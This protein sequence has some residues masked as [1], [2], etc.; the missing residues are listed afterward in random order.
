MRRQPLPGLARPCRR[1]GTSP[2]RSR[3]RPSARRSSCRSSAP[4]LGS[5]GASRPSSGL[6]EVVEERAHDVDRRRAGVDP[7][8]EVGEPR[9]PAAAS[10]A[11]ADDAGQ[12][13]REVRPARAADCRP[14]RHR[15]RRRAGAGSQ[16]AEQA[17][18]VV[19]ENVP[20]LITTRS[21]GPHDVVSSARIVDRTPANVAVAE[22]G[23]HAGRVDLGVGT[24]LPDDAGDERAVTGLEV[25]RPGLV[26]VGLVLVVDGV[27]GGVRLPA[28]VQV[29]PW[30]APRSAIAGRCAR[31]R[32]PCRWTSC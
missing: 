20:K 9:R 25:E 13:R 23:Q 19:G 5:G 11:D 4:I 8:A 24:E 16:V 14:R 2:G 6:G 21:N 18:L 26:V 22:A 30:L 7:A 27:D 31:G 1:T 3:R 32:S 12:R 10:A 28:L 15:R 29:D 17:R